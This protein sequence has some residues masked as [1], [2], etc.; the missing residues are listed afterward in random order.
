MP[1][2]KMVAAVVVMIGVVILAIIWTVARIRKSKIPD[3]VRGRLVEKFDAATCEPITKTFG[4][5]MKLQKDKL[6]LWKNPETDEYTVV[7]PVTCINCRQ[8]IP[9]PLFTDEMRKKGPG[10]L[11]AALNAYIC[12]LCGKNAGIG[13]PG[14]SAGG[15]PGTPS[16]PRQPS[17]DPFAPPPGAK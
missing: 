16:V 4:E 10:A 3:E 17:P 5:W 13:R 8:K 2:W 9:G 14:P 15:P 7:N 12:P 1:K 6:P 11:A